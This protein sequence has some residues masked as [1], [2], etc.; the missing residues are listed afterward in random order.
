M[1]ILKPD[2]PK[3]LTYYVG[4]QTIGLVAFCS[5]QLPLENL[6]IWTRILK[7]VALVLSNIR[8][9]FILRC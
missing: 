2:V 6:M 5:R 7:A 8:D 1:K 4:F 3:R 9:L